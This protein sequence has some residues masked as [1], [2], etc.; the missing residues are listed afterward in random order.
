MAYGVWRMAYGVWRMA[1]G[2]LG[3]VQVPVRLLFVRP[4]SFGQ[5]PSPRVRSG[6]N[7]DGR[8]REK[9]GA[10]PEPALRAGAGRARALGITPMES[11][12]SKEELQWIVRWTEQAKSAWSASQRAE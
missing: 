4:V 11:P 1:Y 9:A 5:C 8:P 7:R 12:L 6:C 10:A 2:V 3:R